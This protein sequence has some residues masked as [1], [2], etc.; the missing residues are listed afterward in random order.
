MNSTISC[1]T[2]FKSCN[3]NDMIAVMGDLNAKV[4]NNNTD[5]EDVM[6]K[7]GAMNGNGERLFDFFSTNWLIKTG[8]IVPQDIHK[9]TWRSPNRRTINQTD[10]I[11]VNGN[12]Y[13]FITHNTRILFSI[14]LICTNL[15]AVFSHVRKAYT[16]NQNCVQLFHM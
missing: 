6:G 4:G 9:L 2:L 14:K 5:R 13:Y 10:H 3:R 7:F 12:I 16:A 1:R 8:T 11:V 15:Y